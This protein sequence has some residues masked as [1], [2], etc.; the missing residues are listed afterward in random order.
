MSELAGPKLA[1]DDSTRYAPG[2]RIVPAL[3]RYLVRSSLSSLRYQLPISIEDDVV[4]FSSIQSLGE[5]AGIAVSAKNA[6]LLFYSL[7][8]VWQSYFVSN[9][10]GGFNWFSEDGTWQGYLC[11]NSE[12]GFNLFSPDGEWIGYLN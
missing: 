6:F 8:G 5:I 3:I 10:N 4:F 1:S 11:D 2:A 9:S 7:D 12:S